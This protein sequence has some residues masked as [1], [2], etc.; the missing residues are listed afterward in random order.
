MEMEHPLPPA[1]RIIPLIHSVWNVKKTASDTITKMIDGSGNRIIPPIPYSNANTLTAAR[2]L[3]YALVSYHK[4]R[5]F[6]SAKRDLPYASILHFRDACNHRMTY[7]G[8][9]NVG[10]DIIHSIRHD[11]KKDKLLLMNSPPTPD[12]HSTLP[13]RVRI[14]GT[15]ENTK[16]SLP[17]PFSG[18]TPLRNAKQKYELEDTNIPQVI[19]DR[20]KNCT[21]PPV[22]TIPQN[23]NDRLRPKTCIRCGG[24]TS[25]MCAGCHHPFCMTAK[26]KNNKKRENKFAFFERKGRSGETTHEFIQMYCWHQEHK[27]ALFGQDKMTLRSSTESEEP[28]P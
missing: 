9:V 10:V 2:T 22:L 19:H 13:Q 14:Q 5:Q 11:L 21:G 27:S 12:N 4:L 15:F 18:K 17:N 7:K 24:E 16:I 6:F 20:R 1:R 25:W 8:S 23:T 3:N 28:T 26:S